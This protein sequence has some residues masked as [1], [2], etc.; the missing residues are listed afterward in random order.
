MTDDN[1][2][3]RIAR[4]LFNADNGGIVAYLESDEP[5]LMDTDRVIDGTINFA[6]LADAVVSCSL[7]DD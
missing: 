5:D 3:T 4:A 7:P 6:K 2:H 1:L